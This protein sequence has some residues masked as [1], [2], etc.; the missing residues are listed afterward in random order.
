M[1]PTEKPT[2]EILRALQERAKELTCLYRVDE[3]LNRAGIDQ[4]DAMRELV[5]S[6]P[7]GWQYPDTCLVKVILEGRVFRRNGFMEAPWV[8]SAPILFEG[9]EV[10]SLSVYYTERRPN[11]DEGPFLEEERR[12]INTIAERIGYFLLQKKL[13]WVLPGERS[14]DS[15]QEG[16]QRWS[17]IL[18]FLRGTDRAL[19]TRITRRMINHLFYNGVD[20]AEGL[21]QRFHPADADA[22]A[23]EP[24]SNQPQTRNAL[25]D[26]DDLAQEAFQLASTQL[27]EGEVV[28]CVQ[29]WIKEESSGFL[30]SALENL[31]A[32]LPEV[33]DALERVHARGILDLELPL[34]ARTGLR[35]ALLR[36]FF[37]SELSFINCAKEA[38]R[39]EDF[40]ELVR[41]TI[42]FPKTHGKLG[43]KSAGLFVASRLVERSREFESVLTGIRVPRT[44]YIS[45]D[46]LLQFIRYNS[47]EDAYDLKYREVDRIR[48]EYPY[49]IQAF[50]NSP[51]PPE[52]RQGLAAALDD[53][54]DRPI[55]VRS[56]SLLEDRVGSAFSGK[57]KSLFL[58]NQGAK[59]ERLAALQDAVAEIYAS[60]FGP[61]PIEY[62][63][64]R[65]LLDVHEEMGIMIQEVVGS[66]FG[67]YF[68]PAF[69]GVAYSNNEFRWSSRIKREDGLVRIVPGLGTRAVDRLSD[70][71]PVL[72]APGQ[73]GLRV[74]VTPD[75]IV[76]YSPK[77]VDLINLEENRF[78]TVEI[79]DLLRE[80]GRE[81]PGIQQMV[82]A[83]EEGHIRK[84]IGSALDFELGHYAVTFEG[85]I[86][87]SSFVIQVQTMLRLFREQLGFAV[88]IEFAS[89]GVDLYL[90]Q[91]RAQGYSPESMPAA[92]PRNLPRDKVLF[93]A[94][95]YVSNGRVPDITHVVHVDYDGYQSLPDASSMRKVG[96]VVGKL[97]KLLPKRQFILIGPGR[98]GSRGDIKL[99]VSVTY[100]Q[101]NNTA[102]LIEVARQRG[103]YAPDLSFGTHFF[104][105]LVEAEIRYLPLYPDDEDTIFNEAFLRLSR[106]I[107][108]ELLPEA[109]DL[110]DTIRVV[111]IPQETRGEVLRVLLNADLDEAVGLLAA[112]S[113]EASQEER[114][115]PPAELAAEDHWRW[116]FAMAECLASDLDPE[117]FGVEALYLLGSTK[118]ATA[119]PASD[120]DLLVHF[121]GEPQQR[122]TLS[123]WLDG[124][125]LCLAEINY[126]RTGYKTSGLLDVHI[127][128]DE[129]IAR[130]TSYA[131]KIGAITD[132][133]RPLALA[134]G[135]EEPSHQS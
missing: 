2:D 128:T 101:I 77:K 24:E 22:A 73:P 76:R 5:E 94:N 109:A 65:G 52:L 91:C 111:D 69:A 85:L 67:R 62:R 98:W 90:L 110:V 16:G 7:R 133:A 81:I 10:G 3:I 36:R 58:A 47:L 116:R 93:T 21:L 38:V 30:H 41:R 105:D 87:D 135:R 20:A 124:W 9:R 107:L 103:N 12:L 134:Y 127:I 92:I 14:A 40:C 108:P 120:I 4:G 68:L 53:F 122:E 35:V 59:R 45:S 66:R 72:I 119:G 82:S 113:I 23:L 19:L 115:A 42:H 123:L 129:D 27:S 56:S 11:A 48:R 102:V 51:C 8:M 130:K 114:A 106:N 13:R 118:N 49:L 100:S 25:V 131:V 78:E 86:S 32:P 95:R 43:G 79:K 97:N 88:D 132:A 64:E 50:K 17:V 46:G 31:H 1:S 28:R 34:A 55:I 44:W 112:P 6:I 70:D 61:D 104:Q 18:D 29:S 71:Y 83:V 57:Y 15:V 39:V 80:H 89:D 63:A 75:E 54:E 117:R 125:S 126:L 37:S 96:I 26:L 99:G 60:V 33:A 74:N 121:K 84:P